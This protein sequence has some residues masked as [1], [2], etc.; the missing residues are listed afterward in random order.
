MSNFIANLIEP[1]VIA[2]DV[3]APFND[4]QKLFSHPV[5][6]CLVLLVPYDT[7]LNI[8]DLQLFE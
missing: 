1:K 5:L 4:F 7:Q 3:L 6:L 2:V 8:R